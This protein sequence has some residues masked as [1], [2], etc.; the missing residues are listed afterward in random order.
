MRNPIKNKSTCGRSDRRT[1]A[2][3]RRIGLLGLAILGMA[4]LAAC[5]LNG[6]LSIGGEGRM[7]DPMERPQSAMAKEDIMAVQRALADLGYEPGPVDGVVG[8]NTR[9][10]I[11]RYQAAAGLPVDGRISQ[12]L[13]E[14]LQSNP[15][16]AAL[17]MIAGSLPPPDTGREI[18]K[19]DVVINGK[20]MD[21][22]PLYETGDEFAWSN[23]VVETVIRID[24]DRIFWR[25]NNGTSFNADRNFVMPPSSWDRVSGPGSATVNVNAD[26]LWPFPN[27]RP[28]NFQVLTT[29]P[30]GV[31]PE[32]DWTCVPQG[33]KKVTV[34]A[35]TFD[36]R[37]ITCKRSLV[38]DGEWRYRTWFYAPAARHYVRRVDRFADGSIQAI[39]LVAIRPGGKG[40]PA[41]ARA[42]LDWA[43]RDA[44]NERP[45]ASRTDWSSTSV[46]ANFSIMPTGSRTTDED[47]SCRTFVLI[48]QSRDGDRSYPAVACQDKETGDWLVPVL[49]ED[50]LPANEIMKLGRHDFQMPDRT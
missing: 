16:P 43:I 30:S 9:S 18:A 45:V 49:D 10:A 42:G 21:L 14:A 48:R 24:G 13:L 3:V 36:T 1:G 28:V 31:E 38:S 44:L 23:G 33:R 4:T 12:D 27:G 17:S 22:P 37:V 32:R 5:D 39:G 15:V 8:A 46:R 26:G 47:K 2:V 19:G 34:P 7:A 6:L 11:R 40:W 41:A 35:G 25:G 20:N 50:A 29:G